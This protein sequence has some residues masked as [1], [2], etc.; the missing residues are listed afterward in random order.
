MCATC[1]EPV[2]AAGGRGTPVYAPP[3]G[4]ARLRGLLE[5]L[6]AY[7]YSRENDDVDPLI[8]MAVAHYQFEA[9]HPF[10]DGNG[11]TGRVV[12]ILYL[13]EPNLLR[14]PIL[15]LSGYIIRNKIGYCEGLRGVTEN[16]AWEDWI[17]YMLDAVEATARE[18]RDRIVAIRAALDAAL[19]VAIEAMG[20][21]YRKEAVEYVFEN[22]YTKIGSIMRR[23]DVHRTTAS[24]YLQSLE[25][26][27]IL[28]AIRLGREVYYV[29]SELMK[30]LKG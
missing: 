3:E 15:Y 9:I 14:L 22:P 11:R 19:P 21:S 2:S 5:N 18:T 10:S 13:V 25:R 7:L 16:G 6:S 29:N 1:Q 24:T 30:L 27:G 4:E 23:M 26:A 8:R 17:V 12:N 20:R 28:R